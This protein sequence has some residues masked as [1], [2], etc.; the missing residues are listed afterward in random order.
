[1]GSSSH[2]LLPWAPG[3]V[4]PAAQRRA[5]CAAALQRAAAAAPRG[6]PGRTLQGDLLL[7]ALGQGWVHRVRSQAP[8]EEPGDTRMWWD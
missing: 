7:G 5:T 4:P 6:D 8:G 1:M 3:P 2:D